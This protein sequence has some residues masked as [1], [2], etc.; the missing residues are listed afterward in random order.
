VESQPSGS[1]QPA[2]AL[3]G[4]AAGVVNTVESTASA[5]GR[6]VIHSIQGLVA[7]LADA[8]GLGP[9]PA[10]GGGSN[11]LRPTTQPPDSNLAHSGTFSEAQVPQFTSLC[12]AVKYEIANVYADR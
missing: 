8:H 1:I 4:A 2:V 12:F 7:E 11:P 5:G 3:C 6:E 9:C 10:R